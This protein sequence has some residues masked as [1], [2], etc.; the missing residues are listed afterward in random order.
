MADKK[1][2][3]RCKGKRRFWQVH[4]HSWE[5]SGLTQNDYC[6][7]N[8][9]RSNQFC[10]WKKK[11]RENTETPV[12]FIPVPIECKELEV[13]PTDSDSGLTLLLHNEIKIKISNN[14]SSTTLTKVVTALGEQS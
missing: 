8:Q 4:V 14:F 11:L 1:W 12:N 10:Y 13:I 2:S 9:L 6:R 5:K 7:R 3:E